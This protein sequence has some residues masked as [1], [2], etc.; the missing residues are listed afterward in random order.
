M[1]QYPTGGGFLSCHNDKDNTFYPDKMVNLLLPI[2]TRRKLTKN[3]DGK[4]QNYEKGG[5]YY[6][7]DGKKIDIEKIIDN[8]DLIIHNTIIDHGVNCI[9]NDKDLDLVNLCGRITLNF[10]IGLFSKQRL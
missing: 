10:S 8:G 9:D 7:R 5:F 2:T 3:L 1:I 4:L 6:F